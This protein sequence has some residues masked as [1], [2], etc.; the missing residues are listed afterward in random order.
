MSSANKAMAAL[1]AAKQRQNQTPAPVSNESSQT[2]KPLDL[3]KE[4]PAEQASQ[5]VSQSAN[6]ESLSTVKSESTLLAAN[7]PTPPTP[8]PPPN[9]SL[10]D[11]PKPQSISPISVAAKPSIT[12]VDLSIAGT[13]H[14]IS[15]PTEE[16]ANLNKTADA[17]NKN[18]RELRSGIIGKSPSNEELLVLHCLELYDKI[19]ELEEE[20]AD[21]LA[22][23]KDAE[24]MIDKL[25]KTTQ[26]I[27]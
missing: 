15:C 27:L 13:P 10:S 20:K 3:P 18:L 14:R 12:R 22:E 8:N 6:Q 16:V 5:P 21:F 11:D 17:L 24:A 23:Q 2:P 19:R 25:L 9:L 4:K 1:Q 26:A 7:K